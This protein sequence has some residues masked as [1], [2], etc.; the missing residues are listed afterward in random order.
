MP[1]IRGQSLQR[2][3]DA[4]GPL[5]LDTTV[6][7]AKQVADA[8]DY[9]HRENIVHRDVKPANI[10]LEEDRVWVADFGIARALVRTEADPITS[11]TLAVGTPSYMSPE[12]ARG[13]QS[14]IDGRADQYALACVV[15]EML[16]GTPPFTGPTREAILAR[17]ALDPVPSLLTVRPSLP[18]GIDLVLGR[19]LAKAPADRYPT[20]TAF[21]QA[22]SQAPLAAARATARRIGLRVAAILAVGAIGWRVWPRPADSATRLGVLPLVVVGNGNLVGEDVATALVDLI[23]TSDTLL[24]RYADARDPPASGDWAAST[25]ERAAAATGA[26]TLVTGRVYLADSIRVQLQV[27]PVRRVRTREVSATLPA[28][29]TAFQVAAAGAREVLALLLPTGGRLEQA[30]VASASIPALSAYLEG[31]RAYRRG[32]YRQADS[33]FGLA[34]SRDSSYAWAAL[35]GAQ[36]ASWL[37]DRARAQ[38]Y[39]GVALRSASRLGPR[40]LAFAQGLDAYQRGQADLALERLRRARSLDPRWAEAYM[41]MGEVYHHYLPQAGYVVDSAVMAFDSAR[42]IDQGFTAPLFHAAQLAIWLSSWDRAD[43]L[44]GRLAAAASDSSPEV[45]QLRLMRSCQRG[46]SRPTWARAATQSIGTAAQAATWLVAGVK[47]RPKGTSGFRSIGDQL[48]PRLPRPR[49]DE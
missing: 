22:L 47:F 10:L 38:H 44:I 33:L 5:P 16:A 30:A 2:R 19:A 11:A 41:A 45:R 46:G 49:C 13:G 29:A 7:I 21:V 23:N 39:L 9:A 8:L 27:G 36:A 17:H 14:P 37:A 20:V 18:A 6:A 1:H 43:S 48:S 31:E 3:L 34:V 32:R 35:R 42:A 4:V 28:T 25:L 24:A 12:Q 15:Y 40:Y 26:R